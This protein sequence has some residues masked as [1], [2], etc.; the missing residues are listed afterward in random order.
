MLT[1][2]Y[3][4]DR[5]Y[6]RDAFETLISEASHVRI[7]HD[8][9]GD[10]K[11]IAQTASGEVATWISNREGH[12]DRAYIMNGDGQTIATVVPDGNPTAVAGDAGS[13]KQEAA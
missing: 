7:V 6:F 1:I 11:V 3:E 4:M 2:R 10:R 13:V 5:N 12:F 9:G 8:D